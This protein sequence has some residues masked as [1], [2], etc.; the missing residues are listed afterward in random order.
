MFNSFLFFSRFALSK[1]YRKTYFGIIWIPIRLLV[2]LLATIYLIN[3]GASQLPSTSN[4][5]YVISGYVI[6]T[7]FATASSFSLRSLELSRKFIAV[8]NINELIIP[9]SFSTVGLVDFLLCFFILIVTF[10]WFGQRIWFDLTLLVLS[11]MSSWALSLVIGYSL[12]RFACFYKD[13][14]LSY[15]YFLG[16][17]FFCSTAV[18]DLDSIEEGF[19]YDVVNYNP[20]S[21]SVNLFRCGLHIENCSVS[22]LEYLSVVSI[23][24]VLSIAFFSLMRTA[25]K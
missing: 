19:Y 11:V 13:L 4:L 25:P 14:R 16:F 15:G 8:K 2:P 10:I 22:S 18:V 24:T 6:F 23:A 3:L 21:F 12:S 7:L 17:L 20:L 5:I 1:L 9:I